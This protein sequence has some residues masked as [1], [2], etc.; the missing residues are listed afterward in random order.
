MKMKRFLALCM[1]TVMAFS[2]AACGG[3]SDGS[4][5]AAEG[6][7]DVGDL[8][9]AYL[10]VT[11]S[12]AP[13]PQYIKED[14]QAICDENGWELVGYDGQGDV[15]T[16][17]DQVSSVI[18][19]GEA[20]LALLFSVSSDS[21]VQYVKDLTDAG[22]SV[23]TFGS[24]ISEDG[25]DN[26]KCYVGVDQEKLVDLSAEYAIEQE[27]EGA[28]YIVLSGFEGQYDYVARS[29][30]TTKVFDEAGFE[31]LGDIN[32][33]G[34]SR[35]DASDYATTL[36]NQYGEDINFIFCHSDEFALGAMQAVEEAGLTGKVHIYSM[37]TFAETL[38]Y[39]EDGT[40][41]SSVTMTSQ[42]VADKLGEIIPAVMNGESVDYDQSIEQV[43]VTGD[44]A[45]DYDG[46]LQY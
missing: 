7:A 5:S 30:E 39:L 44:N 10:N 37:E 34:A 26:V 4:D 27:P 15:N 24:D 19:D 21:G 2:M 41:S 25:R 6:G 1:T 20:N 3:S 45:S 18:S 31:M 33:C 22:I 42:A 17:T 35:S 11:D 36:L 13:W 29:A 38:P 9:I 16:Q 23:I 8:T 14:F 46:V 12:L 28:K 43:L 32:F 40:I